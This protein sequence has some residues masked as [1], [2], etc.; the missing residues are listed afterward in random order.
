MSY[1]NIELAHRSRVKVTLSDDVSGPAGASDTSV[2]GVM[3]NRFKA[4]SLQYDYAHTVS[5]CEC[6]SI[7]F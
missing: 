6:A 2:P 3:A 1:L 5:L 4:S 7:G